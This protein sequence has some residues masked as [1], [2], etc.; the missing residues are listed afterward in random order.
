M[1]ALASTPSEERTGLNLVGLGEATESG[2]TQVQLLPLLELPHCESGQSRARCR[3]LL[4]KAEATPKAQ[5]HLLV[6]GQTSC[7]SQ[8]PDLRPDTI[9]GYRYLTI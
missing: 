1:S 9:L 6:D 3:L 2:E 7:M 8:G 5:K 4:R